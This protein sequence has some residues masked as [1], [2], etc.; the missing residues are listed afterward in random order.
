MKLLYFFIFLAVSQLL[1]AQQL[2]A[3]HPSSYPDISVN[4]VFFE[5]KIALKD[6]QEILRFL[7]SK[8]P[9]MFMKGNDLQLTE[10]KESILG[11]HYV[12]GQRFLGKPVFYNG[13]R[14]SV[15]HNGQLIQ[16]V[17][18]FFPCI[19]DFFSATDLQDFDGLVI[20]KNRAYPVNR[21]YHT[22]EHFEQWETFTTY[23]G[24]TLWKH[25]IKKYLNKDTIVRAK[26]FMPNPIQSART[27][28]G[29]PFINDND[30]DVPV[31]LAQQKTVSMRACV[32][33][34]TFYL[35]N[36]L[37]RFGEV[38][39]PK[40][41]P[42]WSLAD[43][44]MFNRSHDFFEDQNAFY[45][46]QKQMDYIKSLGYT[47][48]LDSFIID[49]HAHNGGDNS[50]FNPFYYPYQFEFGTG[51]VEDAEDGQV[52]IHE[53]GHAFFKK[54][55]DGTSIGR[56]RSS[57]EEGV[58]DYFS[59]SYSRTINDHQW[60]KVFS[61]D[62]H[63]EFW[64]GFFASTTKIY[65]R[66][67]RNNENE[68]RE[69]WS[70]P[71]MCI[72]E[73]LG[74]QKTDSLVLSH[75]YLQAPNTTMPQVAR[76]ILKVDT[77]LWGG[78]NMSAIWDCFAQRGI[79]AWGADVNELIAQKTPVEI[80]NS[81]GWATGTGN[82][83]IRPVELSEFEV[84]VLDQNGRILESQKADSA[85][86]LSSSAYKPGTYFLQIR[87]IHGSLLYRKLVKF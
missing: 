42:A 61:W 32:E 53:L 20:I 75:L 52:V 34:D 78:A 84:I 22:G 4:P 16:A 70:S 19:E 26:V 13:V 47:D 33:N 44:F 21:Q 76:V 59:V 62:G 55:A 63:N 60:Y 74:K 81:W 72:H 49:A 82:L 9:D 28:Y 36:G 41:T 38:S 58:C 39:G 40:T 43:S 3:P 83:S 66:D 12:F 5:D 27:I 64:D 1:N 71:L 65:P 23:H 69:I 6:E 73:K 77:L 50:S 87:N 15:G 51:G 80:L 35:K 17:A 29:A 79:L 31:I 37:V 8:L 2:I 14:V 85:I 46:I 10:V 30:K 68:D 24:D 56:E 45:H 67:I 7:E 86:E 25:D 48:L 18:N 57:M 11:K 54:A